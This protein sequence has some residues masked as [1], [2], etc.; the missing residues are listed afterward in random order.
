MNLRFPDNLETKDRFRLIDALLQ[1]DCL[2]TPASRDAVAQS[3]PN[4]INGKIKRFPDAKMDVNSILNACLQFDDG[5]ARF[6]ETIR[7][8]ENEKSKPWQAVERIINE[9]AEAAQIT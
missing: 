9:I 7:Y 4:Q 2:K 6:I 5:V 1:C 3:L 8:F